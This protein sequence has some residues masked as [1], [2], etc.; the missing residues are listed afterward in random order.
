MRCVLRDLE[1]EAS[2]A[3]AP[4]A[5][6]RDQARVGERSGERPPRLAPPDERGA[7]ERQ[8]VVGGGSEGRVRRREIRPESS[9]RTR[10]VLQLLLAEIGERDVELSQHLLV[11]RG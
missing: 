9:D 1:R 5:G 4:N 10:D 6:Q 8:V 11:R 3:A 7:L 2:L